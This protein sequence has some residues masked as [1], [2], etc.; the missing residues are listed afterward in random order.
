MR[1]CCLLPCL[2]VGFAPAAGGGIP[3]IFPTPL[4]PRIANYAITVTY[5]PAEKIL[6]GHERIVWHNPSDV[7]V[8]ELQFHLYL[9][10][11]RGTTSTFARE[12]GGMFRGERLSKNEEGWIEIDSLRTSG[13]IDLRSGLEFIQPDDTNHAD[14]TVARVPLPRPVLPHDS[15]VLDLAFRSKLPRVVARTGYWKD[16]IFV[17]QWFPKLGVFEVPGQRFATAPGWNCHQF[18]AQTEFY[19]DFGVYDVDI[20]LPANYI[21]GSVGSIVRQVDHGDGTKTVECHAEDV[22]DFAW[23]ASPR[24]V[25]LHDA[26][27]GVSLRIL[28]QPEHLAAGAR[29]LSSLKNALEYFDAHVG[30]YP[31]PTFTVVDP[32]FGGEAAGGMEYPTLITVET[33]KGIERYAKLPEVVTIHE[34]GHNY[35]Y[36]MVASNEFEEGWMDEGIDQYYEM[37]IMDSLYGQSTSALVVGGLRIGDSELDRYS[38]TSMENPSIAPLSTPTWKL[39]RRGG[40]S[41]TYFKTAMVL[42]TLEG[43]LG[44]PVMDSIMKVYFQ[45]WK[46]RHPCGRDFI[47]VFNELAPSLTHGRCGQDLNWYFNQTL[48]GTGICDYEL[49]S[50]SSSA[51]ARA[52]SAK[53]VYET[54]VVVSRLGEVS[55]PVDVEVRFADGTTAREHWDGESRYMRFGFTRPTKAL[56][57]VVDPDH[58]VALDINVLN[59]SKTLSPS[60]SIADRYFARMLFWVQN[61]F[62]LASIF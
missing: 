25:V 1:W 59:N 29:Y 40:G 5:H 24:F 13:G 43:L 31:Y 50:L 11:F 48:N 14:R 58:I 9:N 61:L 21:V 3:T 54:T 17:G 44:R 33:V 35:W 32:P 22:H 28:V 47:N 18:H 16:F 55:L 53:P 7:A 41:L 36:G 27:R 34:F 60:S 51:D 49:T 30:R 52:D 56:A 15:I 23:S 26:W 6:D 12:S 20:T 37:R 38:Y 57:A 45:R 10:A 46:F 8:N 62:Q 39:P 4:S 19:A 42:K 2:I